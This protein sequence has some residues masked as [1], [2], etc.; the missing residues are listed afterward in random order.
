MARRRFQPPERAS[1]RSDAV[2]EAGAAEG[3]VDAGVA[4]EIVEVFA[5]DGVGDDLV[6]GLAGGEFDVL[7]DV[8]GARVA[9]HGDGAGI[10]LDLAGED[11]EQGGFAGAV[12]ADQAEAFAF[13]DAEGDVLEEEAGAEGFG[14]AGAAFEE[15]HFRVPIGLTHSGGPPRGR[16]GRLSRRARRRRRRR[17]R[18]RR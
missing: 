9:A 4:F 18:R 14:E 11:A 13:G 1:V 3:L 12:A 2:G 17:P 7:R 6:D 16:V 15:S 10:G 5:G 8:A